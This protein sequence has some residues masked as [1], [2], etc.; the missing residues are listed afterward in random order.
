MP[1]PP[2]MKGPLVLQPHEVTDLSKPENDNKFSNRKA[3]KSLN[4]LTDKLVGRRGKNV[5]K[6]IARRI[7]ELGRKSKVDSEETQKD[8]VG[9]NG[10]GDCLEGLGESRSGG[11]RMPWEKDEGFVFRRMKKEKI[12]SSAELRLER[13]L[14]ERLRSE[15]RKMRKWVKVKKAGVSKEIVE[16]V[17]FVWK[18]NELAMVKFDVP[19][20]RNMD[21]AQEILEVGFLV[22]NFLSHFV[23]RI[24]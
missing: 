17:K 19:L 1:T 20:C 18:S 21:R 9:K 12:V 11:E 2:W 6:K 22:M 8:F 3:E 4:G 10:I 5:I 16:D 13:E 14:L 23:M 15:A 24:P 7:E